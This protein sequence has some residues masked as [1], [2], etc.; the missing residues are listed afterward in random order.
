MSPTPQ[1]LADLLACREFVELVTDYLEGALAPERQAIFKAHLRDCE[2]CEIYLE[3][4]RITVGLLGAL[5]HGPP[6]SERTAAAL[7]AAARRS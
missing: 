1:S 5:S 2:G 7:R 3:Q 6:V 4:I